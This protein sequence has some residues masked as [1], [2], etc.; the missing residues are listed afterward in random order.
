[1]SRRDLFLTGPGP[2]S[3]SSKPFKD[4]WFQEPEK[5]GIDGAA[6]CPTAGVAA[7]TLN[8][9]SKSNFR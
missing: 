7:I 3:G 1:V 8:V 5:S 6:V 2:D 4:A 9:I